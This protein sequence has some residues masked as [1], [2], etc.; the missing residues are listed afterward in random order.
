MQQQQQAF[1]NNAPTTPNIVEQQY[2]LYNSL[3]VQELTTFTETALPTSCVLTLDYL[4]VDTIDT[5]FRDVLTVLPRLEYIAFSCSKGNRLA[6]DSC[7]ETFL[8]MLATSNS[9]VAILPL[10]RC[11]GGPR[12]KTRS[13]ETRSL[14][15]G[16]SSV[17][18]TPIS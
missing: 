17:K 3:L 14:T 2:E 4:S 11:L 8:D 13:F 6:V 10:R 12:G 5:I 15:T 16:A 1:R 18:D 7:R 9:I